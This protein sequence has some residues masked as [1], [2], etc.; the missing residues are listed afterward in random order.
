MD[1]GD[2]TEALT[3]MSEPAWHFWVRYHASN[4]FTRHTLKK[5]SNHNAMSVT[6]S[7]CQWKE[8]LFVPRLGG[9]SQAGTT[10]ANFKGR[11]PL[12]SSH[13]NEEPRTRL[14]SFPSTQPD[15]TDRGFVLYHEKKNSSL[16]ALPWS[17][18]FL[19]YSL[20]SP[21]L[22]LPETLWHTRVWFPPLCRRSEAGRTCHPSV[23]FMSSD[24][25]Q[26]WDFAANRHS[27]ARPT[28]ALAA[29]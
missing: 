7:T 24:P 6:S 26:V 21:P 2:S 1:S 14:A 23:S 27:E 4:S 11:L 8:I 17:A 29:I 16:I 9:P 15:R 22:E 12:F 10:E 13:S 3:Y 20:N 18:A 5:P 28:L 25:R 19:L